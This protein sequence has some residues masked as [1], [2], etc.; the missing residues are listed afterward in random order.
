ARRNLVAAGAGVLLAGVLGTV[1]TLGLTS[2]SDPQ[3]GTGTSTE[4]QVPDDDSI[5]DEET[6]P[7]EPADGAPT[8]VSP[9]GQPTG[10]AP[11]GVTPEATG[12]GT[13]SPEGESPSATPSAPDDAPVSSST[14]PEPSGTTS[15]GR[16]ITPSPGMSGTKP[17]GSTSAEPDPESPAP[18]ET[19]TEDTEGGAGEGAVES[20][21][22][23]PGPSGGAR[24]SGEAVQP[25]PAG[26]A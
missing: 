6:V 21:S 23:G 22:G 3:G 17:S 12:S 19:Q 16:P 11:T 18:T 14:A 1:V 2:S 5:Y 9:S 15:S 20:A 13:A 24:I 25:A 10:P 7:G 26:R 8:T 4:Q